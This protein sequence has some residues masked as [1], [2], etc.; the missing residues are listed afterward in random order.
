MRKTLS[1]MAN[2][3]IKYV[4]SQSLVYVSA[5]TCCLFILI[6]PIVLQVCDTHDWS[7]LCTSI[8]FAL[9]IAALI[10]CCK[11]RWITY[12]I[13]AIL[14]IFTFAEIIMVVSFGQFII[15]GNILATLTT[16]AEESASFAKNAVQILWY[17]IP[18][19]GTYG[20]LVF[21]LSCFDLNRKFSLAV[22]G[23]SLFLIV[24]FV[25][26]KQVIFSNN[27]LTLRYYVENRIWDR[28]PFNMFYQI[29]N[30]VK[31][32]RI[33]K[34]IAHAQ[35]C[36]FGA[37]K[38]E[39][40]QKEI[41]VLGIGESMRYHNLSLNGCY[42]R[43][44][45]PRLEA[46]DNVILYDN[47]YSSSCLTMYS[48]PQIL[49]RA[50]PQDYALNY[51][52]KS[53]FKPFQEVGFKTYCIVCKNLLTY[54]KYLTDGVDSLFCVEGDKDI[55]RL[56]DSLSSIYPKT[57]FIVQ[58]LGNHSFYY[59]YEPAFDIYKPNIN[60]NPEDKSFQAYLNAYDNTMLYADYILSEIIRSID[61][62]HTI[63]GFVFVSDH[64]EILSEDTLDG[65]KY[66]HGGNCNP[67]KVEYHIPLIAWYSNT[68]SEIYPN[69]VVNLKRYTQRPIN[70]D[71]VFYSVCDMADISIAPQYIKPEW[72][73]FGDSLQD[74]TR[75]ILVPDGI[76]YIE[77]E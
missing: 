47:Y 68:Y 9:P 2:E 44:T 46:L 53:V 48:V 36:N 25:G 31:G 64:G 61:K 14:S 4:L 73:I 49:T 21:L 22:C 11:P 33:K 70:A 34:A 63:S 32:Q 18:V 38:P 75:Y 57:F 37:T 6:A 30:V 17:F 69:K 67:N 13:L 59:N 8:L 66:G 52:E 58:F 74:H 19:I 54:E 60:D 55:P 50:T 23:A 77:V 24:G 51:K 56:I 20:L 76:N 41:Y 40:S 26:Y 5:Y 16:T 27:T 45:T 72:S 1:I 29:H 71:N 7:Y 42:N 39:I 65:G 28:P 62:Q 3:K 15:A 35:Y 10:L 12:V 43:S